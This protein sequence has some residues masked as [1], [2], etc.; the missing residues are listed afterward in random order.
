MAT[1]PR[2]IG[3]EVLLGFAVPVAF[4]VKETRPQP[5]CARRTV[6]A[7]LGEQSVTPTTIFQIADIEGGAG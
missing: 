2:R 7:S 6:R 3:E 4:D 1:T 5:Q